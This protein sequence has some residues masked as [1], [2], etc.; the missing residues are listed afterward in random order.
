ME[1]ST[2]TPGL[3][4]ARA[5]VHRAHAVS[6]SPSLLRVEA[7]LRQ[8]D[9]TARQLA[10]LIEGS[11]ALAARVLR[12][13]NSAFYAPAEPVVSLSRAV[14]ILGDTVLRQLVLTS[15][16]VSR[17]ASS[18]TPRQALAAARLTGDAVRAAVVARTLAAA[19]RRADADE[20]FAGG[21]LHDLGHVYLL[22]EVGELYASHLLEARRA[23][24]SADAQLAVEREL[25]GTTHQEVGAVFAYDWNLPPVI[26]QVMWDHHASEPGSLAA[27]VAT[28]D[29]LVAELAAPALVA[30]GDDPGAAA[31]LAA[32]TEAVE[33]GLA[34]LGL[35]RA[36]WADELATVRERTTELLTLFDAEAA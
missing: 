11:P 7:Q 8:G 31:A 15:L 4:R 25:S 18:R 3:D 13:A 28:T 20:A 33:A 12:M 34:G 1:T 30:L 21:L 2:A 29:R 36:R 10:R 22:D 9:A 27:L 17:R 32:R 5:I 16:I 24:Q 26:A 6:P 35:D 19:S 23:D 14:A